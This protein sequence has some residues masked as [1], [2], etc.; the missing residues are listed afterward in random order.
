MRSGYLKVK[1]GK[2]KKEN[3]KWTL[4][5]LTLIVCVASVPL[6][7]GYLLEGGDLRASLGRIEAVSQGLGHFFPVRTGICPVPDFGYGAVSFQADVFY[8]IPAVF[9]LFG[10]GLGTA[11]GLSL[12]LANLGTALVAFHCFEKC[13]GR[14]DI[15]MAGS[16]L[17]TWCPCRLDEVYVNGNLGNIAAW[18]FLPLILSGIIRLYG[19]EQEKEGYDNLWIPFTWGFSL[20]AVSSTSIFFV[21]VGMVVLAVL[22]MGRRSLRKRTLLVLG[23]TAVFSL[24]LNAWFL[25]PMLLRL[26]D[27]ANV[28]MLLSRDFQALGTYFVQ[29]LSVYHWGGRDTSYFENGLAGARAM[30][31][32]I[33]VTALVIFRLWILFTGRYEQKEEKAVFA[34]R[35]LWLCLVLIFLSS[36]RFPWD[37]FED[38]NMLCSIL[39]AMLQTPTKW[40]V[41]ACVCLVAIACVTLWQAAGQETE[42]RVRILLFAATAASFGTTQ[43]FIGNL[44]KTGYYIRPEEIMLNVMSIPLVTQ[45]SMVWRMCEIIS[46][47]A[48]CGCLAMYILRSRKSGENV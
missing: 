44:L 22:C 38:R 18:T 17:Y 8:L 11:Y 40:T 20:L 16:M 9:R 24:L 37:L 30:G 1:E 29:Y 42:K 26:R 46:V 39:L 7:T 12:F 10:M 47:L 4:F 19:M 43:F 28:E 14:W 13:F 5:G 25:I 3:G 33:A 35:M 15:A 34:N 32:G 36:C 27:A 2:E 41:P 45:E 48:L 31:P 21:M 23:R 6:M